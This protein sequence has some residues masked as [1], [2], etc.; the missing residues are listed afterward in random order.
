MLLCKKCGSKTILATAFVTYFDPDEEPYESGVREECGYEDG[1]A[2]EVSVGIH[3]CP[4]CDDIEDVWIEEPMEKDA[5]VAKLK[6]AV[7]QRFC[8]HYRDIGNRNFRARRERGMIMTEETPKWRTKTYTIVGWI[9]FGLV[10][11][12]LAVD[13]TL[14]II[15]KFFDFPTLSNYVSRR[16]ENQ[17]WFGVII[18]AALVFLIFHWLG[19]WYRRWIRKK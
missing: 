12:V 2:A 16:A 15:D 14:A 5:R 19:R 10:I 13:A 17:F 18:L 6:K 7:R 9:G 4:K 8:K 3:W 1:I 11:L